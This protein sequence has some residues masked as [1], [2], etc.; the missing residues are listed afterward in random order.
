MT[1]EQDSWPPGLAEEMRAAALL[2][3]GDEALQAIM[4]Q[5]HKPARIRL[6]EAGQLLAL[7]DEHGPF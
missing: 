2:F 1:G 5:V 7:Q 4:A 6:S 3:P